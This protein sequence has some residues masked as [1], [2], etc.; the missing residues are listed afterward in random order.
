MKLEEVARAFE[1]FKKETER[2]LT[3]ME[4]VLRLREED[5]KPEPKK[6]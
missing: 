2:R 6:T 3:A 5:K 1:E 4:S